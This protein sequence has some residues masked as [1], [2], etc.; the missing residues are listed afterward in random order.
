[1]ADA[2]GK[3]HSCIQ[4][5]GTVEKAT[6]LELVPVQEQAPERLPSQPNGIPAHA[7]AWSI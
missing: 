4:A 3:I 5:S 6:F 2:I 7:R 1:M